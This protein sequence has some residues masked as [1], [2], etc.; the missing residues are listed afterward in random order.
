MSFSAAKAA[1]FPTRLQD[2]RGD[3]PQINLSIRFPTATFRAGPA[4]RLEPRPWPGALAQDSA[5]GAR[6]KEPRACPWG[7]TSCLVF[8][9]ILLSA[10]R[11]GAEIL[12]EPRIGFHGVFQLG[13]P[14][15]LEVELNNSGRPAE[16]VLEVQVW[17]GGATKGGNPYPLLY[18]K[19]IFLPAQ[20]RKT[21]QLTIEPD[22]ISRPL[23]IT[24]AGPGARA[25]RELDLRRY[26]SPAPVML[27]VSDGLAISPIAQGSFASNRLVALSLAELPSDPRALLGVSHLILYE[28]SMRELSRSQL[29]A[30]D[31]WLSAGGRMVI[32]GSLNYALYQ[33]AALGRFLPVRV[34][35]AQR[36]SFVPSLGK[37]QRALPIADVWAQS[38]TVVGGKV[39][40]EAQGLPVLVEASRGKGRVTY[41]SLDVGRP[42]LSRWEGLPGFLQ[43]LLAPVPGDDSSPRTQWDDGIFSQLVLS[44]SF[45]SAYVPNHS[46]FLALVGYAIGL[47]V[48]TWLWQS[49]RLPARTLFIGCAVWAALAGAAGYLLFSRGG[50]IPDGVL[51]AATVI[52]SSADGYV[53]AQSNLALFS[54]QIRPY[55]LQIER[56]WMELTPVASR[57][58]EALEPAVVIQEGGG[59]SRYQLPL[60]EW[61]YRLFRLRAV[62]RFPLRA[63]FEPQGDRLLMKVD[64]QSAKDLTDCWLV[65]PG[66]RYALGDI[67][68][69]ASWNRTFSLGGSKPPAEMG[70]VR[71]DGVNFRD[72]TF[73]DKTREILFHSS[74]FP[75]G[76]AAAPWN[77]SAAVFFGWVKDPERRV[78]VDDPRIRVRDYT[79]FRAIVPL[80]GTEDE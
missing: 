75:R 25:S 9:F 80:G 17:R 8:L 43:N 50:N 18:R 70:S 38:S 44:P 48:I 66:Q 33:E 64:N 61:D 24:F 32:L 78:G 71:A 55:N 72:V 16:G 10:G 3:R 2:L 31:T 63:E 76:N 42:P 39:L 74:F 12:I 41:L 15:P 26:F 5:P 11:S 7:S 56:G 47:G 57:S 14:F 46:L 28:A 59:A 40:A 54:T 23:V 21:V 19:E 29:L 51:L 73:A 65:M 27:L 69:G 6:R 58:R 1:A 67:P 77:G 52:E 22:F 35:G 4:L 68:R 53:E 36:I 34:T 79:L 37:N 49:K 13:R 30:L 62:E 20:S 45:I 60:R